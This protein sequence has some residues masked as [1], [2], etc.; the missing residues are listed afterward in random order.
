MAL[1]NFQDVCLSFG[2]P[3]LLN[4]INLQ[5]HEGEKI[6][7][8][9]RNGAGKSTMMRLIHGLAEP[10]SGRII[11]EKFLRTSL[12]Q[13]EVPDNFTGT[14]YSILSGGISDADGPV[15]PDHLEQKHIRQIE[16]V[17]SLMTL[18][19]G[20]EFMSLSAGMKRR[21][22]LGRALVNDPDILLLDEPTNHLDIDSI[23]WLEDFLCRYDKTIFF[24]TH[25]RAFLQKVA[26]RILEID[27]GNIFDWKC[28]YNTFL[29]RKESWLES[30]ETQNALFDKKLAREEIWIRKGIKARRTRNEGR[31]RAL[32]EMR[33]ERSRRLEQQGNVR[34]EL[35]RGE[36]SGKAVIEAADI[37]FA[38]DENRII[39]NF[40]TIIQRGDKIGIIGPNGCGKSTLIKLLLGIL[41]PASGSVKTGTKLEVAYFDQLR[42][43]IDENKTIRENIAEAGEMIDING[44]S[45]HVI[46]YLQDF[47]F[48]PDRVDIRASVLSG[49]ER[50]R[51]MLA[52]LFTRPFNFL[53]MDEPTND[54]D[55]ET[56]ELLEQILIEYEGTL[57]VVSH[58]REFLNNIVTGTFAF[59]GN[60]E[61]KEYAGGYDEWLARRAQVRETKE[62]KIQPEKK[63]K[64]KT[65]LTFKEK[66]E[67]ETI[68]EMIAAVEK[69]KDELVALISDP[70]FYKK[71]A[72][73][74]VEVNREIGELDAE[75]E[76][77]M[78]RWLELEEMSA[79]EQKR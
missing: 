27:R 25:D 79:L 50:N 23:R 52:K 39:H 55:L 47:L 66:R 38:Y 31:V 28:D 2:G 4:F 40:S 56:V 62:K 32:K 71:N 13:Q 37:S 16:R 7:L 75:H 49:G 67:L 30:E 51:L 3:N 5:I 15:D 54:L 11:R 68:P 78:Q 42:G 45:R 34:L 57:L 29:K 17:L 63:P 21:V 72:A 18:D 14:V 19:P 69:K 26:V 20:P 77:L 41:K 6:S 33:L 61:V 43:S 59:E 70:E 22:L 24:V 74:S 58:D 60:G 9:G 36:K 46:G 48:Q 64:E 12:L 53:V 44:R 35:S 65:K 76:R 73:R 1:L 8:L 10:D